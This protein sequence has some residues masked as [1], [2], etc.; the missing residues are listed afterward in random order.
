MGPSHLGAEAL[1]LRGPADDEEGGN[2][3]HRVKGAH[4]VVLTGRKQ[5]LVLGS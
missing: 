2:W 3:E 5:G 1:G 4:R